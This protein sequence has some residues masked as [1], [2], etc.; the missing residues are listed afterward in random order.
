MPNDG[1]TLKEKYALLRKKQLGGSGPEKSISKKAAPARPATN[2]AEEGDKNREQLLLI[3]EKKRQEEAAAEK[4]KKSSG[5]KLP[6]ALQRALAEDPDLI[7]NQK[8]VLST[9]G[10]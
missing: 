6:S 9:V 3:L 2:S 1:L 10:T 8:V 4:A 5:R 7:R